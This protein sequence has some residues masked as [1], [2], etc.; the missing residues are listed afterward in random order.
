MEPKM[1]EH[2]IQLNGLCALCGSLV[3]E[4][5]SISYGHKE[6]MI[7]KKVAEQIDEKIE[8]KLIEEKKLALVLDIDNTLVHTTPESRINDKPNVDNE[9]IYEFKF[10]ESPHLCYVKFRPYLREF[11]EQLE[12]FYQFHVYTHGSRQYANILIPLIDPKSQFFKPGVTNVITRDDIKNKNT[13][14]L[15][16]LFPFKDNMAL[17]LDDR[18]DV[19]TSGNLI[20][21]NLIKVQPYYYFDEISDEDDLFPVLKPLLLEIHSRFYNKQQNDTKLILREMRESVLKG[22]NILFSGLIPLE[23]VP[24]Q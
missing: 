12:P 6:I 15:E 11:L 4:S 9:N 23:T 16:H 5:E 3:S 20:C 19:W 18:E 13:K 10:P 8:K 14:N 17:I 22:C 24:D 2:G 21:P 7:S 1:C